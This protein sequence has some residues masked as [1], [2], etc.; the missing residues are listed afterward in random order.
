MNTLTPRQKLVYDV[1][2]Y[3]SYMPTKEVVEATQ[4]NKCTVHMALNELKAKGLVRKD[5]LP[6]GGRAA[7]WRRVAQ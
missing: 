5:K 7:M 1:L 2:Q 6:Q 3:T 4:L